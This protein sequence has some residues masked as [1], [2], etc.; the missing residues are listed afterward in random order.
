LLSGSLGEADGEHSEEVTIKGLGLYECLDGGVPFLHN[1][2]Q[3]VSGDVHTVE[4]GVAVKAL[5]FFDLHLHFSPG[6]IIA[7]SVQI[8]QRYF[9]HTTLQTISSL[10]YK[11]S[12]L[13]GKWE[14][15][16]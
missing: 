9:E 1:G 6:L 5:H 4:V 10:L 13:R 16:L 7:F 2:A 8:S 3:L 11:E 14:N 12:T 15:L